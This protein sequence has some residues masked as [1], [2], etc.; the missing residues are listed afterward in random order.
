MSS[1]FLKELP[2]IE[3]VP[4][5]DTRWRD[6]ME[7]YEAIVFNPE[8]DGFSRELEE[9]GEVP[10]RS[11]LEIKDSP[12][13]VGYELLDHRCGYDFDKTLPIMA[14]SGVKWARLQSGWPR[15]EQTEG[16]YDFAWLDHIVDSL[17][18]IG[19][20]P[21][22]SL[23]F[24]NKI[25]MD[26][27]GVGPHKTLM[28]SPTV[29]GERAIRG[30]E[31]YCK[32]MAEHFRGRVTHYEVWNE[33]NAGFLRKPH[34]G[35]KI[36]PDDP[37]EYAKLVAITE[38]AL[39]CVD[40]DLTIIGGS[41]S[42]GGLCNGYIRDLF[43][44]GIA[45]HIDIFSY[46]P[47]GSIPELYWPE[48]LQYIKDLIARSGKD[49]QVWQ[50]ENGR[51]SAWNITKKGWKYTQMNQA[52]HLTRRYLTDL[53]LGITMSSYFLCCDIGNGYNPNG[54]VYSQGVIDANDDNNYKPK[55]SFRAMQSFAR[56]FDSETHPMNVN[57][58]VH[59]YPSWS[60][61]THPVDNYTFIS[62]GFCRKNI[63]LY[64]YY[65]PSH[66]DSD[67]ETHSCTL[68]LFKER[69]LRFDRP[70][71]IDPITA[72]IYRLKQVYAYHQNGD[73]MCLEM[74]H[75][76]LLDYPLFLTDASFFEA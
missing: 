4:V 2:P 68:T 29:F 51:P 73:S 67:Y 70:I 21:W 30:W 37:A 38:K 20:R 49:I 53:R 46:H 24:G 19:I 12:L 71:L 36:V 48:R 28:F 60:H 23:S 61:L 15:A 58:E 41:I 26:A 31:N 47:Y 75:M 11:S 22:V 10:F 18:A 9:I 5:F 7:K 34:L 35:S 33:P 69:G 13:G 32:K 66:I 52:K 45:E 14:K 39:H 3:P 1:N 72:K 55:V 16:V 44:N 56:L 17:L 65:H 74:R 6:D 76:P 62:A 43:E 57:V 54:K 25:Y 40:P 42:G 59:P 50:G 8:Y 63:P 64:T 27:E